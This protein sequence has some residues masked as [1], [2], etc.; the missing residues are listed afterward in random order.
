MKYIIGISA[1]YHDSSVC[2][3][4]YGQLIFACE[5]EKFSG[6][7]HDSSFP[8]KAIAYIAKKYKIDKSDVEAVCYYEDPQLKL[9]RVKENIRPQIFNNLRYSINSYIKIKSNIKD[10]H[11]KLLE[12][13][14]NVFYSTHHESHLYYSFYTSDF[15]DAM[16]V[17]IDGVGESDT[18]AYGLPTKR[19]IKYLPVA[20]YP[21]SLGLFYSAMTAFLGFRPNEGEYK[22][23]GLSSYGKP[24][25]F[26]KQ[27]KTLVNFDNA[28]LTCN[29]DAFT[30][31]RSNETMFDELKLIDILGIC[32]RQPND[33]INSDHEDLAAAVQLVYEEILFK[34]IEFL[35]DWYS[36]PNLCLG[37]G[38]SY[39]G[40]A[41]GKIISNTKYEH[42]WVPPAPSDAGSSIGA[43]IHYLVKNGQMEGRISKNP[44]LGPIYENS[45]IRKAVELRD[46]GRQHLHAA[47]TQI[48]QQPE[49]AGNLLV[50][51]MT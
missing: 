23:M 7:K 5:E 44:F 15:K 30:W 50:R 49:S 3:F 17:S 11:K 4:R 18:I 31:N 38:C 39:N 14:S 20:H 9:K 32:S 45:D 8:S 41:N 25:K 12:L 27:V 2:L 10:I 6:I 29:M 16:C 26:L 51:E 28:N 19:G 35:N 22:V 37:G 33:P 42:I 34:I 21:H 1:Y 13:S 24:E 40:L 46:A 47:D 43:C 48:K 36:S